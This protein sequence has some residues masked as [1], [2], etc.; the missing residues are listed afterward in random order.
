[1]DTVVQ[2]LYDLVD[3]TIIFSTKDQGFDYRKINENE[4]HNCINK[5]T[6]ESNKSNKCN[7]STG[8]CRMTDSKCTLILPK[9]NLITG[10]DNE[11][12]YYGRMA[13]ELI[14]Y[15]RIKSFIFKPQAYLSFGQIKYNLRDNEIIILQDLLNTD[16]FKDLVPAIIN[17]YAKNQTYDTAAPIVSKN[18]T[19]EVALDEVINPNHERNC[20]QSAPA[21]ISSVLWRKRFPAKYSEVGYTGSNFCAIYLIIDVV[22][23][24]LKKRLT[25]EDVKDDLIDEYLR[26]TDNYKDITKVNK[27]IDILKEEGQIDAGQL[28]DRTISFEQMIIHEGFSAVNFDLWMLLNKYKIPSI[29]ISSKGIPESRFNK[30]EF[31]CYRKELELNARNTYNQFF[32]PE[33][34]GNEISLVIENLINNN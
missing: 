8:I 7:E 23:Q 22:E 17:R 34:A 9:N 11:K 13:D 32:S 21:I 20:F 12:Y 28:Q 1:L 27:I 31:V 5:T 26:L 3:N 2:L 16:F 10:S 25:V 15:N 30:T 24:F 6:S 33:S 19:N 18:Y 14:R 4:M 29:F